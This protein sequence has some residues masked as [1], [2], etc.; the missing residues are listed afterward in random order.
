MYPKTIFIFAHANAYNK[1]SNIEALLIEYK[2]FQ[3][4]IDHQSVTEMQKNRIQEIAKDKEINVDV[5][6]L[7]KHEA[8]LWILL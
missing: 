7:N 2:N 1:P 4:I 8:N 3:N 6:A 5:I